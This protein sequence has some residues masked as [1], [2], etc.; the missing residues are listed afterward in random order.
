MVDSSETDR[1]PSGWH[2][3]WYEEQAAKDR[4]SSWFWLRATLFS[5]FILFGMFCGLVAQA[6]KIGVRVR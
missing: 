5:P 1:G 6:R 3:S 2:P 4:A